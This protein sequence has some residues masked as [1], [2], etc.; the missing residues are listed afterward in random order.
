MPPSARMQNPLRPLSCFVLV[1]SSY[2]F[3]REKWGLCCWVVE[4]EEEEGMGGEGGVFSFLTA[5]VKGFSIGFQLF[6]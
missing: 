2:G 3:G 1:S 4:G 6:F 5:F